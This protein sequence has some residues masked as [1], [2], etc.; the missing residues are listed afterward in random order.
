MKTTA[1]TSA[2][3][4]T[5]TTTSINGY[6][7]LD[8][9]K[10]KIPELVLSGV[11]EQVLHPQLH[12]L[13]GHFHVSWTKDNR[14]FCFVAQTEASNTRMSLRALALNAR[15]IERSHGDTCH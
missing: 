1:P 8:N 12:L 3:T 11:L 13:F 4:M 14:Y 6:M 5:I 10:L 15:N 7:E 2:T 9:N